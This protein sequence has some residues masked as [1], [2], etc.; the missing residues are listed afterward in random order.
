MAVGDYARSINKVIKNYID[1]KLL[2]ANTSQALDLAEEEDKEENKDNIK[3]NFKLK[4]ARSFIKRSQLS[5]FLTISRF[6]SLT[7][8]QFFLI[9]S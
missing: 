3:N 1:P 5:L 9:P 2:A 8:S 6:S 7:P 4:L